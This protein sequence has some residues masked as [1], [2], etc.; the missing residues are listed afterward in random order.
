MDDVTNG[1]HIVDEKIVKRQIVESIFVG[2]VENG[3]LHVE[4]RA[5]EEIIV[6]FESSMVEFLRAP[7]DEKPEFEITIDYRNTLHK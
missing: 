1:S 4:D 5:S 7:D 6:E 2:A 3:E